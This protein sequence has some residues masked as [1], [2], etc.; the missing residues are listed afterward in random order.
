MSN[1]L[2]FYT[3]DGDFTKIVTHPRYKVEKEYLVTTLNHIT[4]QMLDDYCR[5]IYLKGQLLR[6]TKYT[7][8]SHKKVCLVLNQGRNR[9]IRRIFSH[10]GV[11]IKGIKRQ[12]IGIISVA[13]I[14]AGAY[15][16]LNQSE[17]QWFLCKNKKLE[18]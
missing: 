11:K 10:F 12:R 18:K 3:N 9:E 15:R 13:G 7:L 8:I 14:K 1:G 17:V 4:E 2:I 5:G 6:L 16:Q